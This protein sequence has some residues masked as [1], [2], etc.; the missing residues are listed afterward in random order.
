LTEIKKNKITIARVWPRHEGQVSSRMSV[1]SGLDKQKYETK[2]VY[3]MKNTESPNLFEQMGYKTF[4][5]CRKKYFRVFNLRVICK[6]AR[7]FRREKIDILHS[8][9]HLATVYGTIAAKMAGV[10]VVLTHVPGLNR[11]K[12]FRRKLINWLVFRWVSKILTTGEAVRE[13]VL[14]NNF[15]LPSDRVIS[16]GN[17]IDFDRFAT[18]RADSEQIKESLGL[19]PGSFVFGTIGRLA[20][21]KG[22]SY[23]IDA[24]A[25]VKQAIPNAELVFIGD[26]R[27]KNELQQ[28]AKNTTCSKSIHFLG[29]RDDIPELLRALDAFVLTSVAEGMPRSLLEAMAANVPCI[30]TDVGG[31]PEIIDDG[32]FGSLVTPANRQELAE[33]M[34]T[35]AGMKEAERNALT[36][37]AK[38]NVEKKYRNEKIIKKL[39][40]IYQSEMIAKR[41]FSKYL[42]NEIELLEVGQESMAIGQLHVQYNPERF[43]QYKYLHKGR[44]ETVLDMS[45]SPH[46]RMLADYEANKKEFLANMTKNDYYRMQRLFGKSHKAAISKVTRLVR[47]YESIGKDGFTSEIIVVTKPVIANEYNSGYEIYT[48]H[49]RVACCIN[50]GIKLVPSRI[51]E[52]RPKTIVSAER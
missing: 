22:Y 42:K 27:L 28:Q 8:H 7:V 12:R 36:E 30:A 48:G 32:K 47:L 19:R 17:S 34:I 51:M 13:D 16:L 14:Q 3:L 41:G 40:N 15:A 43:G 6:M 38:Q 26:G 18:V 31:I 44:P 50:L 2:V 10:P 52:A 25:D 49:H 5:L 9:G 46:C 45:D 4:Y 33:A 20:P 24:F 11:S 21:T 39:Q 23:L 1:I 37:R 29:R 35:L